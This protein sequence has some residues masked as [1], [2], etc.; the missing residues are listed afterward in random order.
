MT[1]LLLTHTK[2]N[3]N[4]ELKTLLPTSEI[5]LSVTTREEAF[6]IMHT[7]PSEIALILLDAESDVVDSCKQLR[8]ESLTA[9]LPIIAIL[10]NPAQ[11][12]AV[13]QAGANDW[14]S[15]P[16]SP[17]VLQ[18]RLSPYLGQKHDRPFKV[19]LNTLKDVKEGIPFVQALIEN[20]SMLAD[21]LGAVTSTLYLGGDRPVE[22]A[23]DHTLSQ[24]LFG[25]QNQMGI[26]RLEYDHPVTLTPAERQTIE[27]ISAIIG[28]L[29][30]V[31]SL[32]EESQFYAT[33]TAFLVLIA[34]MLAEKSEIKEMLPLTLEH[35]VS[36]LNASS[37]DI[38]LYT[39]NGEELEMA[40]SL[41]DS[42]TYHPR[43]N[44]PVDKGV[45]GWVI[46]QSKPAHFDA[47]GTVPQFDADVDGTLLNNGRFL[48]AIPLHH[49]HT[50]GVIVIQSHTHPFSSQDFMLLEGIANLL[51]SAIAN[52][53][54][55]EALH[56]YADQQQALYE[57][58]H[59]I[60]GGLD[61]QSTLNR[62]LGWA[63]RLVQIETGLLWL[64]DEEQK[65]LHLSASHGLINLPE[66]EILID[67]CILGDFLKIA[68]PIIINDPKN[69]PRY[70][71]RLEKRIGCTPHNLLS[72]PLIYHGEPIGSLC[73]L[74][75]IGADFDNA[76]A[77]LITTATEMIALA[78][79]NARLHAQTVALM[80]E[81][82]RLYQQA[83]QS[84]RLATIGRLTASLA[85]EIN[86]PMQAIKGALTLALEELDDPVSLREYLELAIGQAD[87]VAKLVGRMRQIYRPH[88]DAPEAV[89][90]N[91][92]L[93]ET[94]AVSRKEMRRQNTKLE[95][96]FLPDL[97]AVW[98]SANQLHLVFLNTSLNVCDMIGRRGGGTLFLRTYATP[99]TVRIEFT[100]A[101]SLIPVANIAKLLQGEIP[102]EIGLGLS[103]SRDITIAHGGTLQLLEQN[104]QVTFRIELPTL[105]KS[106]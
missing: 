81:R 65:H 102:E 52:V 55:M 76:D 88:T 21:T 100:T 28:H 11:R 86:N 4:Q 71:S 68:H 95:V 98:A 10:A 25:E 106:G 49:Q 20:Q 3:L 24:P 13:M 37:G 66:E 56:D 79:G 104:E 77:E 78:I 93:Q 9:V 44:V 91:H 64:I 94:I 83:V 14:L 31:S 15:R 1:I 59:Q 33:Q 7:A 92:I 6:S 67:G 90:L 48:L 12:N 43:D 39:V 29:L 85:H 41:S 50:L 89:D 69:D 32:Q 84:E 99:S 61:L 40:S 87:R 73:L 53:V 18:S 22:E 60:A 63:V 54:K 38:W 23:T 46:T 74:D 75:K 8:E 16:L 36:L 101:V 17:V 45:L 103:L 47:L 19:L 97:P 51:A 72:V 80:D 58:S 105:N 96:S 42:V 57:M 34:K 30:E 62:A 70:A 35:A 5:V 2:S 27:T 82:E 26:L